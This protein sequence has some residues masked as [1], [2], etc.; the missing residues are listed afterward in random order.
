VGVNPT[1]TGILDVLQQMG[2]QIIMTPLAPICG[3]PIADLTVRSSSLKGTVIEGELI[4]RTLDEFP[5]LCVA[6]AA[7]EGE[8]I[9]RGAGELRVKE[10]DRIATMAKALRG[11]GVAV[12][13][14]PDGM[15]IQG[16]KKWRGTECETHGDH[17]VAMAMT[18]AGLLAEGGN[19]IDDEEC[20]NTSFPGFMNL[21]SGLI[22]T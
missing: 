13:E 15:K 2:A 5:I 19:R 1:R 14:F 17:R 20:I 3:E 22:Q 4:P 7:A 16:S 11:M 12:E 8:T 18:V 10:S 9:I 6:A 21:L